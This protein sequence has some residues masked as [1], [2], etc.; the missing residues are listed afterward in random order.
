[1]RNGLFEQSRM[2]RLSKLSVCD[3]LLFIPLALYANDAME[4][5]GKQQ[6]PTWLE[7]QSWKGPKFFATV[8]TDQLLCYLFM[9]YSGVVE[10][11][12][13]K[14]RITLP[15]SS[16]VSQSTAVLFERA[17]SPVSPGAML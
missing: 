3:C 8:E 16:R 12:P 7:V 4:V 14:I 11:G 13:A 9:T 5:P 17:C 10:S 6:L 2:F 1:M 15:S